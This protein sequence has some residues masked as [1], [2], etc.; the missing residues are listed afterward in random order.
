MG[1]NSYGDKKKLRPVV[2]SPYPPDGARQFLKK[3]ALPTMEWGEAWHWSLRLKTSPDQLIGSICL[4]SREEDHRGFW[5]APPSR[6]R[7]LM[8]EA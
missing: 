8:S 1:K 7:G 6:G 5:L 3:V 2:P 4:K